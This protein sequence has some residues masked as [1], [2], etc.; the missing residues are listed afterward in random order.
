MHIVWILKVKL[1][2]SEVDIYVSNVNFA[3]KNLNDT[4]IN[5]EF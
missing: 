2:F 3:Y 1:I 5:L 4:A